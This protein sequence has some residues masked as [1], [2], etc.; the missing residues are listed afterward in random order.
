[1]NCPTCGRP[2]S[3]I[4]GI[5]EQNSRWICNHTDCL[6]HHQGVLCPQCSSAPVYVQVFGIGAFGYGCDQGHLWRNF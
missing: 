1:M 4:R 3:D 5:G 6:S 2:M